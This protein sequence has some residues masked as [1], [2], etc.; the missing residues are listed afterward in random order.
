[1]ASNS[2]RDRATRSRCLVTITRL[3]EELKQANSLIEEMRE[4]LFSKDRKIEVLERRCGITQ[5]RE[6]DVRSRRWWLI[7]LRDHDT[8]AYEILMRTIHQTLVFG[9]GIKELFQSKSN[10]ILKE[11][12]KS[13]IRL[14]FSQTP[15]TV[16]DGAARWQ[17]G[18][19][20]RVNDYPIN[21]YGI[22]FVSS[23]SV[24][25]DEDQGEVIKNG[26][27]RCSSIDWLSGSIPK[28]ELLESCKTNN[29]NIKASWN[30]YKII[31][32]M[33]NHDKKIEN[34]KK[35]INELT[36]EE[37]KEIIRKKEIETKQE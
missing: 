6:W 33:L 18:K 37:L 23:P 34:E 15:F 27:I 7:W 11:R 16:P 8:D 20:S 21:I 5:R 17:E 14:P 3:E 4:E 35:T 13:L 2:Q 32:V 22:K 30:K 31:E 29:I 28:K 9:V 10:F 25:W 36:L 26:N 12:K 19:V 24:T 1:M